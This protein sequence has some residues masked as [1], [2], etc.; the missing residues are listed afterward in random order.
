VETTLGK[1][2]SDD[3]ARLALHAL[4]NPGKL[5]K[6]RLLIKIEEIG[7]SSTFYKFAVSASKIPRMDFFGGSDTYF[8]ITRPR[9]GD[10][11]KGG[12]VQV[13]KSPV[14]KSRDPVFQE[15]VINAAPLLAGDDMTELTI[16]FYDE[17]DN[18]AKDPDLIG[19]A[20][21]TV[22]DI[23]GK[24]WNA[25]LKHPK[26]KKRGTV[27]IRGGSEERPSFL[28]YIRGGLDVSLM[29]AVDGTQSNGKV[30]LASSLHYRD[31]S[32]R[33]KNPYQRAIISVGGVLEAYDSDGKIPVFGFGAKSRKTGKV[34]HCFPL[35][36]IDGDMKECEVDGMAGV[37]EAYNKCFSKLELWGNTRFGPVIRE[38][39]ARCSE[40]PNTYHVLLIIADGM[41]NDM[42]Y[43][44]DAIVEAS[45]HGLSIVICGVGNA[46]FSDMEFLDADDGPLEN[47]N[48][49][50]AVRDCV[51]FVEMGKHEQ[52]PVSLARE[53]LAE[54]PGQVL[55]W[56]KATGL[57]PK[58]GRPPSY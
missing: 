13:Y 30:A 16:T 20:T 14:I 8:T 25:E 19:S 32:G 18:G 7:K 22:A 10:E 50:K 52:F 43:T 58:A 26:K 15:A 24:N 38:A 28:D 40:E 36:N 48:G 2:V 33:V 57:K 51:Q 44:V 12:D 37:L 23:N 42:K 47:S 9:A 54:I 4:H 46:D 5:T 6:G 39:V 27:H 53:T 41:I 45:K 21:F 11:E 35:A 56:A 17:N 29:V 1:I 49:V 55:E 31:P 34:S 3:G